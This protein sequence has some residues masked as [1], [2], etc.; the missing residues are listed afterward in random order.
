MTLGDVTDAA[1]L[2]THIMAKVLHIVAVQPPSELAP[3][4]V[5]VVPKYPV[6]ELQPLSDCWTPRPLAAQSLY[7]AAGHEQRPHSL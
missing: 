1:P 7:M 2:T 5:H 6:P 3:N 4:G